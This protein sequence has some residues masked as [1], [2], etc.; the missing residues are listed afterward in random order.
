MNF[1]LFSEHATRV[2][3]SLLESVVVRAVRWYDAMFGYR[4]GDPAFDL[5]RDDR[6]SAGFAPLAAVI[7]STFEWGGDRLL[8][9]PWHDTVIHEAH[10]RDIM[11]L[12]PAGLEMT[13]EEWLGRAA[14]CLGL[15]LARDHVGVVNDEGERVVGD[16][17]L[18]LL[19]AAPTAVEFMLPALVAEPRWE[20][21]IDTFSAAREGRIFDGGRPYPLGDRS[22]AV[23]RLAARDGRSTA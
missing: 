18:Y 6:D 1:A 20:A 7:D 2:D 13:E 21:M 3:L 8:R 5:S 23:L 12:T 19:N 11:W 17:L 10:V 22:V 4:V 15:R 9:K 14:Q 16:T